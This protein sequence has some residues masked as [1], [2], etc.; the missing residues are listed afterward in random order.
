[1]S[2]M[3]NGEVL[4]EDQ[5]TLPWVRSHGSVLEGEYAVQNV[6]KWLG[7]ESEEREEQD[8]EPHQP[9]GHKLFW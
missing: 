6:Q 2:E 1:M 5:E 7:E 8:R 4:P 3:G 9:Y